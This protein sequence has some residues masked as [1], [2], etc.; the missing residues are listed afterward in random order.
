M[1]GKIIT[2]ESFSKKKTTGGELST[3]PKRRD[4]N[5]PPCKIKGKGKIRPVKIMEREM[6]G[7]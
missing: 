5:C 2:E 3:L 4:G 1:I 7:L 6:S